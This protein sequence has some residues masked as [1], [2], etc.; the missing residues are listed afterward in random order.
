MLQQVTRTLFM[1]PLSKHD[2]KQMW[3]V[4]NMI[5]LQN[6]YINLSKVLVM[7][8]YAICNKRV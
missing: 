2:E 4:E 8:F 1:P 7:D 5:H 6:Q 3:D